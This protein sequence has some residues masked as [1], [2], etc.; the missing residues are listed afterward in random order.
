MAIAMP[1]GL[2]SRRGLDAQTRICLGTFGQAPFTSGP[3]KPRQPESIGGV[4]CVAAFAPAGRQTSSWRRMRSQ[5]I[6]VAASGTT[7]SSLLNTS[8]HL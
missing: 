4:M 3:S 1:Q 5:S 8:A 7:P 2:L 6:V